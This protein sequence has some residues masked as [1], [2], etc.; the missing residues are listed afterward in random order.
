MDKREIIL[1]SE[2]KN[3]LDKI[4]GKKVLV[5]ALLHEIVADSYKDLNG[6]CSDF[7]NS[8][9]KELGVESMTI[10]IYSVNDNAEGMFSIVFHETSEM[11]GGG[12]IDIDDI[13]TLPNCDALDYDIIICN[14]LVAETFVGYKNV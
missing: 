2:A 13:K 1:M 12:G 7:L 14:K 5:L 9:I 10:A 11:G 4:A 3:S 8:T 6:V